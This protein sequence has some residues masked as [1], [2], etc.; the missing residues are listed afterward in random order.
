MKR[1]L[2]NDQIWINKVDK[3]RSL[4]D[5]P[6]LRPLDGLDQGIKNMLTKGHAKLNN[7]TFLPQGPQTFLPQTKEDFL[8]Y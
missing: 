4:T 5:N 7:D 3:Q 6:S 8:I 1:V 2:K